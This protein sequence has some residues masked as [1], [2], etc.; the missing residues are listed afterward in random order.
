MNIFEL[1]FVVLGLV[2]SGL[3]AV[4]FVTR[5]GL[6]GWLPALVLGLGSVYGLVAVLR[7]FSRR[8]RPAPADAQPK[9]KPENK[10]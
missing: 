9:D 6:W 4:P 8:P 3:F 7:L 2:A 5:L 10:K 1:F